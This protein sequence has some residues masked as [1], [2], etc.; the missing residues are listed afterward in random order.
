MVNAEFKD[1]P[2]DLLAPKRKAAAG[3][4][5]AMKNLHRIEIADNLMK[6]FVELTVWPTPAVYRRLLDQA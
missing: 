1:P 6:I 4:S 3:P 5:A 2:R